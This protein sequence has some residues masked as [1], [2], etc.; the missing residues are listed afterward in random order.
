MVWR[1]TATTSPADL[2][3]TPFTSTIRDS[4]APYSALGEYTVPYTTLDQQKDLNLIICFVKRFDT[5]ASGNSFGKLGSPLQ[6]SED[7]AAGYGHGAAGAA[8]A[9]GHPPTTAAGAE[10]VSA[11]CWRSGTDVIVGANSQ[12]TIKIL[13]LE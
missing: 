6:G 3:T 9:A 7:G 2:K 10:F 1:P 11:V 8:A 5:G 4:P 13:K 12:G